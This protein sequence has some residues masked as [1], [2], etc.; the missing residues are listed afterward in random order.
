MKY[1][2]GEGISVS[3]KIKKLTGGTSKR[4]LYPM[5][6]KKF[7]KPPVRPSVNLVTYI[8]IR[9]LTRQSDRKETFIEKEAL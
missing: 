1:P 4:R 8:I 5:N 6:F 9:Q 3:M 2:L 7:M